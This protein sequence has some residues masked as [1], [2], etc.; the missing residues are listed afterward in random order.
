MSPTVLELQ[1]AIRTAVGRFEREVSASFT[2]E[3][4]V[5]IADEVGFAVDKKS[6]PS[7]TTMRAGIR[8]KTGLSESQEAASG[9]PFLKDELQAIADELGVQV[10]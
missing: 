10:E 9:E 7:T 8:V 6:R 5:A 3:E 4:L 2:K 1:N